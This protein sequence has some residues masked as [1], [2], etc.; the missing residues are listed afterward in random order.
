MKSYTR[1]TRSAATIST[2]TA[3]RRAARVAMLPVLL[4]AWVCPLFGG[5]SAW[6]QPA[7]AFAPAIQATPQPAAAQAAPPLQEDA[8]AKA[9][10]IASAGDRPQAIAFL[11]EHLTSKADDADARTLLGIFLSW[12]GRYPEARAE[13]RRV[14]ETNPGY[15][16]AVGALANIELWDGHADMALSLANSVL[17]RNA[18]DV[19]M[20]MVK[21][22][23][24]SALGRVREARDTVEQVLVV[25]IGNPE[26]QNFKRVLQDNATLWAVGYG[27]TADW[28]S[29]GRA[30]WR[31]QQVFIKRQAGFGSVTFT[32]W[33]ADR[34][35]LRDRQYELELYPSLRRG[36]YM[37]IDVAGSEN[38]SLYPAYRAGAHLYQ[39]LGGGFEASFGMT[40]L[41]FTDPVNIYIVSL[42]KY[43]GSWLLIG[44]VFITPNV[45]GTNASYHVA[46]R[47]Y[48]TDK[49]YI[50]LRYHHGAAKETMQ[51]INDVTV[52][53]ADGVSADGMFVLGRRVGVSLR[54]AWE[55]QQR[56][57][58]SDLKQYTSTVTL[59]FRF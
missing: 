15:Y 39:S 19:G 26:A 12:D 59:D 24:E 47:R 9:R 33:Q 8:L 42:S 22:R 52:L 55:N 6:A 56:V 34:Y 29:D 40:R 46:F 5:N 7:A 13:L 36:T 38:Q 3:P 37:Y 35:D 11:E 16:D 28:F 50:G 27:Y 14:L 43:I 23:A 4:C 54:A 53:N 58:Q 17:R 44:Q 48:F 31:E 21:A 1:M 25:D 57:G 45:V 2:A 30:P 32:T 49:D 20:L 51:T 41:G 10:R 18:D